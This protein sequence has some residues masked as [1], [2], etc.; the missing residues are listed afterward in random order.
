MD[1]IQEMTRMQIGLF[2][3]IFFVILILLVDFLDG[4]K[5]KKSYYKNKNVHSKK[6]PF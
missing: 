4:S 3:F 2:G 6:K 5:K 1:F